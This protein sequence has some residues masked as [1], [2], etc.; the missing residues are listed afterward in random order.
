MH[1]PKHYQWNYLFYLVNFICFNISDYVAIGPRFSNTVLQ[2]L[3]VLLKKKLRKVCDQFIPVLTL[4][5][6]LL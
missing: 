1:F 5:R 4:N 3:L 2:A 6:L